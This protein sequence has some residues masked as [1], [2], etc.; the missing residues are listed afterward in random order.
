MQALGSCASPHMLSSTLNMNHAPQAR[1]D[2]AGLCRLD[3]ADAVHPNL[4]PVVAVYLAHMASIASPKPLSLIPK[5]PGIPGLERKI[6]GPH[7]GQCNREA[8]PRSSGPSF[9]CSRPSLDQR[10]RMAGASPPALA[11]SLLPLSALPCPSAALQEGLGLGRPLDSRPADRRST[12]LRVEHERDLLLSRGAAAAFWSV[13][14]S[15]RRFELPARTSP[16]GR[17]VQGRSVG[18]GDSEIKGTTL[19]FT[20]IRIAPAGACAMLS[21]QS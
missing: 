5:V 19:P 13:P 7:T 10:L 6:K 15:A 12:R 16:V 2:Q 9:P 17:G 21:R 18:S 11:C 4:R 20:C 8:H 3:T 1:Q 14:G